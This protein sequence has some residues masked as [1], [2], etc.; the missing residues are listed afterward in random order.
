MRTY[1]VPD[2]LSVISNSIIWIPSVSQVL[3]DIV[4]HLF[5]ESQEDD[6]EI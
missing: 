4:M 1:P 3:A 6:S 2:C 5:K